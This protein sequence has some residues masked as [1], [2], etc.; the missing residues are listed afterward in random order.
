MYIDLIVF[1][2]VIESRRLLLKLLQCCLRPSSGDFTLTMH[3]P[4]GWAIG[5]E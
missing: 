5:V 1:S 2:D 4:R 3:G